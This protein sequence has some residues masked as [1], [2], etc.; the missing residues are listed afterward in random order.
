MATVKKTTFEE[1]Q[2][3]KDEAFLALTPL[4][5]W[6]YAYN[7]RKKMYKPGVNYSFKGMKVTVKKLS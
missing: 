5:Q 2:K 6:E 7:V 4:Q 3:M 1:E